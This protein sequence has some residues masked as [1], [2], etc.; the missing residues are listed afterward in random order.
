MTPGSITLGPRH[1][2]VQSY[3]LQIFLEKLMRTNVLFG[4][5]VCISILVFVE[6]KKLFELKT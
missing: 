6:P 2:V 5:D 1:C 4:T 3:G